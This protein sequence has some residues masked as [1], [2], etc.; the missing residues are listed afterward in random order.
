MGLNTTPATLVVG[1]F[2]TPAIW[3]VEIRDN[4]TALGLGAIMGT[5]ISTATNGTATAGGAVEI[6]D[7]VLGN[8]TFTAVAGRRYRAVLDGLGVDTT[9][10]A[11]LICVR[12][13][14]G[15][16]SAPTITSTAVAAAQSRP[17]VAGGTGDESVVL[18]NTFVPGA[19]VVTLGASIQ[20]LVGTGV[21]MMIAIQAVP[22]QLYAVDLGPA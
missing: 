15:G 18:G 20:R 12:I 6:M 3:N 2:V 1:T 8:Y 21:E 22:R 10:A 19:G 4:M 7:A 11:D 17:A 5:P 14:N 9:V 16:A 13:R